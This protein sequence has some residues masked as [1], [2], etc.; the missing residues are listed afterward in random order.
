[1]PRIAIDPDTPVTAPI[2][3]D[4]REPISVTYRLALSTR[5]L[6][7]RV[8]SAS[9]RGE[10]RAK[11]LVRLIA[12]HLT[13]WDVTDA[14]DGNTAPPPVTIARLPVEYLLAIE[15]RILAQAECR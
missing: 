7:H 5:T 12:D 1:M 2:A 4:G 15:D 3:P 10:D 6:A 11:R 14:A 13:G 9:D 8:D